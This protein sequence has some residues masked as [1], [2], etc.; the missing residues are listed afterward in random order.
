MYFMGAVAGPG[1]GTEED[2]GQ[3][4]ETPTFSPEL[5][6]LFSEKVLKSQEP[7]S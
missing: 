2:L 5:K 4:V 1:A 3:R 6:K 7:H